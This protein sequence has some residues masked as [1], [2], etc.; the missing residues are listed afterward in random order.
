MADARGVNR[1][2]ILS[3]GHMVIIGLPGAPPIY[4]GHH[5]QSVASPACRGTSCLLDT[6]PTKGHHHPVRGITSGAHH[7][8]SAHV[9]KITSWQGHSRRIRGTTDLSGGHQ[10]CIS[11]TTGTPGSSMA[12]QGTTDVSGIPPA[13]Q[14]YHRRSEG[15][16]IS[17]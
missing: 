3:L 10:W 16:E 12:Y 2:K 13:Y 7:E 8:L 9:R 1:V 14:G 11:G 5:R 15:C 17:T 6:Q 4:R